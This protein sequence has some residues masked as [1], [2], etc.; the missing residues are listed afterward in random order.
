[1]P[2]DQV[3]GL[4][5]KGSR[6]RAIPYVPIDAK[7]TWVDCGCKASFSQFNKEGKVWATLCMSHRMALQFAARA[8]GHALLRAWVRAQG[9]TNAA[10][11]RFAEAESNQAEKEKKEQAAP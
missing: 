2:G 8:G 5:L 11:K 10:V 3:G 9:G 1:M 4:S 6:A 7:C